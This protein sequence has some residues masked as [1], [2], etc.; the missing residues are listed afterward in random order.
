MSILDDILKMCDDSAE[1][2]DDEKKQIKAE[3][4]AA[5]DSEMGGAD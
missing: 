3:C 2:T 1:L 4:K 5:Y